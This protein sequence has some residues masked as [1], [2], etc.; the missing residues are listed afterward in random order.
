MK[1][2]KKTIRLPII[3]K[4]DIQKLK[5]IKR[6]NKL[7]DSIRNSEIKAVQAL[8]L[9]PILIISTENRI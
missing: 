7:I 9:L 2:N 5:L 8:L 6:R 3:I 4:L 1:P